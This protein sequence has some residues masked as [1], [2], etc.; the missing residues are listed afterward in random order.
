MLFSKNVSTQSRRLLNLFGKRFLTKTFNYN[1]F[2]SN[3]KFLTTINSSRSIISRNFST[4]NNI[5]EKESI[6][7]IEAGVFEI[8][9]SAQKLKHDKLNRTATMEELGK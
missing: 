3:K 2:C 9:K 5:S 8:L 6:E 1:T 4:N 7:L